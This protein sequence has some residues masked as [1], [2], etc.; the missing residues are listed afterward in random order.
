MLSKI[1]QFVYFLLVEFS[2]RFQ[3]K[4]NL[5]KRTLF[6]KNRC[7]LCRETRKYNIFKLL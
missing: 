6:G 3:D 4:F 2:V 7:H 1:V 5:N